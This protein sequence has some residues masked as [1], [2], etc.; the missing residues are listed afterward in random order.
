MKPPIRHVSVTFT[1]SF[2]QGVA[3]RFLA[4]HQNFDVF[5]GLSMIGLLRFL[6]GAVYV[7]SALIAITMLEL[8][9]AFRS[10]PW[11]DKALALL[12]TKMLAL[13][14]GAGITVVLWHIIH[15][16]HRKQL[17]GPHPKLPTHWH[18]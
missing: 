10:Q 14:L 5:R 12:T 16:L 17:C 4:S 3:W 7:Y 8:V 2:R 9:L 6:R 18:I 11:T 1:N 13:G 15:N